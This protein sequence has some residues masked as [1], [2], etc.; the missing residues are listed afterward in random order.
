MY[1]SLMRLLLTWDQ[2]S[3]SRSHKKTR[4][5]ET[6]QAT[7]EELVDALVHQTTAVEA[8]SR[9]AVSIATLRAHKT[10]HESET[11]VADLA[12]TT[13][14][15]SPLGVLDETPSIDTTAEDGADHAPLHMAATAD[16]QS[17]MVEWKMIYRYQDALLATYRMC[18]SSS[19]MILIVNSSSGPRSRFKHVVCVSTSYTSHRT[20]PKRL[21]SSD[22]SWKAYK[23]WFDCRGCI[24]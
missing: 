22:R 7:T 11:I 13:A 10:L 8:I 4:A 12:M 18:R 16:H 14:V 19:L 6:T 5:L 24:N 15:P 1:D 2:T 9:R 23:L 20:W 21:S 3:R 17:G